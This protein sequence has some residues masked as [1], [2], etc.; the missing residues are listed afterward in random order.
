M[1]SEILPFFLASIVAFSLGWFSPGYSNEINEEVKLIPQIIQT[2][3]DFLKIEI[4]GH[5]FWVIYSGH[6]EDCPCEKGGYY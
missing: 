3:G 1:F 5:Y 4:N 6:S 2:T